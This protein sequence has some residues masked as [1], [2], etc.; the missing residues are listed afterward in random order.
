MAER[1][2]TIEELQRRL[3]EAE[4]TVSRLERRLTDQDAAEQRAEKALRASEERYRSLVDN[5]G[6][7]V[8]A[9]DAEARFTYVSQASA[10][11]GFARDPGAVADTLHLASDDDVADDIDHR[12]TC[13]SFS[14]A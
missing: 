14:G 7:L 1:P 3:A 12:T 5:L 4:Q 6:D 13:D 9:T 8:Y 10:R 2:D 11:F